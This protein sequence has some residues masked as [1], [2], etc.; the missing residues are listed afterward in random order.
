MENLSN[1]RDAAKDLTGARSFCVAGKEVVCPHCGGRYFEM[2]SVQLETQGISFLNLDW[3][4][5]NAS[6]LVCTRCS[7]IEWFLKHP[8]VKDED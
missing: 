5:R 4:S 3:A 8:E 1:S 7:H 2:G 6:V